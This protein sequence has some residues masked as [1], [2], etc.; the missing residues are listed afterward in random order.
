ME[1]RPGGTV[2]AGDELGGAPDGA[3][4]ADAPVPPVPLVGDVPVGRGRG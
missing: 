3:V 2:G 1:V 4:L